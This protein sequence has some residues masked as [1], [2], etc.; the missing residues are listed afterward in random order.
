[1]IFFSFFDNGVNVC[2]GVNLFFTF[3]YNLDMQIS[4]KKRACAV[5]C[6]FHS[7]IGLLNCSIF[8]ELCIIV[9]QKFF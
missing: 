8:S 4:I 1:M 3:L 5:Y 9:Y 7:F 6:E 2:T